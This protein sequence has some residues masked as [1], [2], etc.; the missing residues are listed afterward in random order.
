MR[1]RGVP[2]DD[3]GEV[4]GDVD[5]TKIVKDGGNPSTGMMKPLTGTEFRMDFADQLCVKR[6]PHYL[7]GDFDLHE[8]PQGSQSD[9]FSAYSAGYK[10]GFGGH[11]KQKPSA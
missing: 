11:I 3:I 9:S 5:A 8:T 1:S 2:I 4:H 10:R 7:V 6:L